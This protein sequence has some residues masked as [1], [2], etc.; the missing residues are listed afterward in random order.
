MSKV[1]KCLVIVYDDY[2]NVLIAERG[3]GKK[4]SPKLWGIFGRNLRGKENGETCAAKVIDKDLS[5]TIFDLDLFKE[6]PLNSEENG[7]LL[8]YTGKVREMLSLHKEINKVKWISLR[9]IDNYEFRE[10][11]KEIIM[12]FFNSIKQLLSMDKK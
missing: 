9:E 8:V 12:D 5:C 6:Y 1:I 11:E 7:S 3:K 2:N 4:D 10:G